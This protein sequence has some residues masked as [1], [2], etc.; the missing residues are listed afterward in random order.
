MS[1]WQKNIGAIT[2]FVEDLDRARSFYQEVFERQPAF[3]DETDAMF[4]LEN[5]LLFLTK[6]SEAPS[7]SQAAGTWL[8]IVHL[9]PTA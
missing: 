3:A 5:T 4:R 9:R 6:S 8:S 2:L 1:D 7:W